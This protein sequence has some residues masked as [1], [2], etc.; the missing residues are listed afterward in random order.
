MRTFTVIWHYIGNHGSMQVDA[1]TREAAM[2]RVIRGFSDDFA[3]R[4]TLCAIEGVHVFRTASSL[5]EIEVLATRG[6]RAILENGAGTWIVDQDM[7][8]DEDLMIWIV[9][10]GGTR[11]RVNVSAIAEFLPADGVACSAGGGAR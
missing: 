8:T 10:S 7:V 6:C 2:R 11:G 4:A 1:C 5:A 3:K 9:S